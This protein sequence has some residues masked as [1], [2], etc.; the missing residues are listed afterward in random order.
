MSRTNGYSY[1]LVP[2]KF[3]IPFYMNVTWSG[4]VREVHTLQVF[5]SN[6]CVEDRVYFFLTLSLAIRITQIL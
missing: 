6:V 3:I 2:I 4:H 1:I 5:E